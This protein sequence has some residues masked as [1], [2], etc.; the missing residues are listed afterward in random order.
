[1][2]RIPVI[3]DKRPSKWQVPSLFEMVIVLVTPG[4]LWWK[5]KPISCYGALRE[6]TCMVNDKQL[7]C[8]IE[9]TLEKVR[10]QHYDW[11]SVA[12]RKIEP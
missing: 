1:M 4:S 5:F 12:I 10:T 6:I 3:S 11:R 8:E 2:H 7:T 9:R